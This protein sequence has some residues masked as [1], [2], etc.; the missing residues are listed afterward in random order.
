MSGLPKIES[1][2]GFELVIVTGSVSDT[3]FGTLT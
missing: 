2:P 1:M 3:L